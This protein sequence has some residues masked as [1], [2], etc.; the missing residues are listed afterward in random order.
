MDERYSELDRTVVQ[1]STTMLE[2]D[3][4]DLDMSSL[5]LG[6]I[7]EVLPADQDSNRTAEQSEERRGYIHE[8]TVLVIDD[9]TPSYTIIE[10]VLLTPDSPS[11]IDDFEERLPRP[12]T[13]LVTGDDLDTSLQ[14]ID[15]HNLNGDR[16]VVGFIGGKLHKP[17]IVRWWPHSRNSLDVATSGGG[18]EGNTLDQS[19][20][21]FRRTNGVET[22]ITSRG[23]VSFSTTW[24]NSVQDPSL[25]AT[26]GRIH[27]EPDPD[28]GGSVVVFI[29]PTQSFEMNW[30][31]QQ[32][33]LGVN[34]AP[35]P[36]LPQTNP[37]E[38]ETEPAEKEYTY[39]F[40]D[41]DQVDVITPATVLVNAGE[42]I[43]LQAPRINLENEFGEAVDPIILG[44]EHRQ[45]FINTFQVL[46][47]F[48]PLKIDP[49][50][51]VAGSLYD[52]T[53]SEYF[54]VE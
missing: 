47:P 17:F 8:C 5:M 30:T 7:L 20:R 14:G 23:D 51:V 13:G 26:E 52:A 35:E 11:G 21:Y 37:K 19:R 41:Q 4:K 9:G 49:T 6:I 2:R 44:E 15:P 48:G 45:W 32:D 38:A 42:K 12:T 3:Y 29:K 43:T 18:I 22:V 46:S 33:G 39:I 1:T 50:T 27:R 28:E 40:I 53:Q 16:C 36:E 25:A 10:H 34:D 54:F 24:T 31:A